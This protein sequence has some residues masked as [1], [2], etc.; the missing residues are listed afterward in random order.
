[1]YADIYEIKYLK[2]FDIKVWVE[3]S[4]GGKSTGPTKKKKP[5]TRSR[6][7]WEKDEEK[8]EISLPAIVHQ[9]PKDITQ[10]PDIFI[11]LFT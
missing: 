10:V 6:V 7:L 2:D 9:F 11:D 5:T 8:N 1:M 3:V 4:V